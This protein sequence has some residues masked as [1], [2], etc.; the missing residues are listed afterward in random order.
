MEKDSAK[1]LQRIF[2]KVRNERV[3]PAGHEGIDCWQH[4]PHHMQWLHLTSVKVPQE[5]LIE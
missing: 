2:A 4:C 3:L 5:R 1:T